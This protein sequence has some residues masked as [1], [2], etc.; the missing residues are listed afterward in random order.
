[1]AHYI[2][3]CAFAIIILLFGWL[4]DWAYGL[5]TLATQRRTLMGIH[6][7]FTG[8]YLGTV[9]L[10]CIAVV[11]SLDNTRFRFIAHHL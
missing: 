11:D 10:T 3:S 7:A 6:W 2:P 8:T 4:L 5:I 9:E 1:M